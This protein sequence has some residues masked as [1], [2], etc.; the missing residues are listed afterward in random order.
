MTTKAKTLTVLALASAVPLAWAQTT[1]TAT[2]SQQPAPALSPLEQSIKDIKNPTP[3]LN[4][5]TDLR[6]RN[7]YVLNAATLN[8]ANRVNEQDFFRFRGRVWTSITPIEDLS[9]NARLAAEPREFFKPAY[10]STAG[11]QGHSDS[12]ME[13]R[14]GIVDTLN[15]QWRKPLDLPATLTVGR[16]DIFL[17]DGWLVGDGTPFDGSFTFFMDAA[18][19]TWDLKDQHTTI[20]AIGIVQNARPDA[21]LPTLGPSTEADPRAYPL[22]D[23]N[24]KGAI[25]WVANKSIPEANF[26]GYFMFKHDTPVTGLPHTP[27]AGTGDY[28][29]IF[30]PGGRV[31]GLVAEHWKYSA[32]G[33]YQF[34]WKED[35]FLLHDE[36]GDVTTD[37]R[38]L[39]A[40]GV[41][42][43]VSYLVKDPLNNQFNFSYEFLSGDDKNTRTD[44]MFDVMWGRWPRWSEMAPYVWSPGTET[45]VAQMNNLHRLGPGWAFTPMKDMDFSLYYFVLLADQDTPTRTGNPS[46]FTD[47]SNF[48][49]HYLQA[50]LKYK[51]NQ[52]FSGHLWGETWFPGDY[53]THHA[54]LAFLRAELLMTF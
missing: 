39:S 25:L 37:H 6:L 32:E 27:L 45:R 53:Y 10:T 15:V 51:F 40:F 38:A 54:T 16:Q 34:G 52:H 14:Y 42:S 46:L 1:P 17:G 4:W 24:E 29:D 11:H 3:W 31:S 41:N 7:E 22:T 19:L 44:E 43:K 13:W 26:D 49:G 2:T 20:D 8:P 21:W 12:G 28:G 47:N 50:I 35:P 18:R 36:T 33:A 48:R 23:Q 9:L 30:T 5:G